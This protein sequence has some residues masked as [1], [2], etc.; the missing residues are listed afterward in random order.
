[1]CSCN[2][3]GL[4]TC[5]YKLR[6]NSREY[7]L[8]CVCGRSTLTKIKKNVCLNRKLVCLKPPRKKTYAG[9]L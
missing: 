5:R 9:K 8:Q 1:M 7:V 2:L 6:I 4:L 3:L